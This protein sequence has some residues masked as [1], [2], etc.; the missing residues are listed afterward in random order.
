MPN[1]KCYPIS[2]PNAQWNYCPSFGAA[3]LFICL[4]G[5]TT[6]THILQAML[7]KKPFAWVLIMGGVW[8]TGGYIF[9]T[10]SVEHQLNAA[11]A[12]VQ[13]LLIL[14]APLWINAFAYMVLGRMVHFFL[15]DDKVF[16]LKAKRV[17]LI[18]VLCDISTFLVQAAG[19]SMISSANPVST[20]RTGLHIYMGGVGMQLLT[21]LVF[22]TLC[23]RFQ[24]K[25]RRQEQSG[26]IAGQ[27]I[28]MKDFNSPI[29]ARHLLYL[30][31]LVLGLIVF[32]NTYRLVEFSSGVLSNITMHEW[33]A[34]VFDAV[35]MFFALVAFNILHPGRILRGPNSDFSEDRKRAKAEKKEKKRMKKE[36]KAE[37]KV[38]KAEAKYAK[39]EEA[40]RKKAQKKGHFERVEHV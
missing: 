37:K 11:Y 33:Y 36:V 40:Q 3:I 15:T 29:N 5:L 16:G 19:G 2:N 10:F 6:L 34:Y 12:T 21:I 7:H 24:L 4:F 26:L 23:I 1:F 22:L 17:T 20:Q 30:L 28:H 25:I 32:R 13:V 8:E 18:F 31:Y 14:L 35:P 39:K 9:R 27:G 38:V